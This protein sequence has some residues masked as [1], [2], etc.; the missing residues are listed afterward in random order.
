MQY[1]IIFLALS[2]LFPL[3][4]IFQQLVHSENDWYL[5]RWKELII[6]H[7]YHNSLD[8]HFVKSHLYSLVHNGAVACRLKSFEIT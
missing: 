7:V 3:R 5:Q 4:S 6:R 2:L 8:Y 1:I